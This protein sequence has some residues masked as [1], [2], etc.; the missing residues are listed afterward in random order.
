VIWL[1]IDGALGAFS[2][3]VVAS[4]AA[5]AP[6]TAIAAGS[7]ALERGLTLVDEVLD[8]L[9]FAQVGAIAVGI[10]PGGFTGLRIALSYAKSLAFA[11]GLPLVGVSSYDALQT[12]TPE[13]D[14]PAGATV[15]FV[16]GRP[17][18]ACARL[19]M[20]G[21]PDHVVCGT[22]TEIATDLASRLPRGAVVRTVGNAEGAAFALGERYA[23]VLSV[24]ASVVVPALAVVRHALV[25]GNPGGP[26]ALRADYGEAHYAEQAPR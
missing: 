24:P 10:G 20:A 26:H 13:G 9:A 12:A 16:H 17:G 2:A 18:I 22:Y 3:A 15:A 1:G 4:D 8:G 14:G 25:A 11:A 19:Q 7:D 21:T 5:F 6:R 23:T